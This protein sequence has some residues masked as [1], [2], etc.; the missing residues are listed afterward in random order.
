MNIEKIKKY[1]K[2]QKKDLRE[3]LERF[4]DEDE[5]PKG[6]WDTKFPQFDGGN[7][8][9]A[10]DEVEEYDSLKSIEHSLE[11]KLKRTEEALERIKKDTYGKC[12]EC[13]EDINEKRLNLIPE[14]DSCENCS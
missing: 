7:L 1:L 9:E 13:G 6:D 11:L 4:A 2:E 8:E 12:S 10:A 14:A 3:M 5:K